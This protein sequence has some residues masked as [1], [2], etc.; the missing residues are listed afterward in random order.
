MVELQ[1]RVIAS[2]GDIL[3]A[4]Q[5]NNT[6]V[7]THGGPMRILLLLLQNQALEDFHTISVRNLETVSVDHQ[8]LKAVLASVPR[9]L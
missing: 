4:R 9:A 6:L 7:F 5:N 8:T 2:I 3:I 1:S